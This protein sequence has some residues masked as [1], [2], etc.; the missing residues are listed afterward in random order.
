MGNSG[1]FGRTLIVIG[2]NVRAPAMDDQPGEG[3]WRRDAEVPLG[4]T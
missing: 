4:R 3:T 1:R 2:E